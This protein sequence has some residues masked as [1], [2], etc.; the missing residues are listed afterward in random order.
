MVLVGSAAPARADTGDTLLTIGYVL[1]VGLGGITTAVNGVALA[2]DQPSTHAWRLLGIT[3]G[4][5]DL[6]LG[7]AVFATNGDTSAG[8]VLGSIGVAV[9]AAALLTGV[10][11]KEDA[12]SVG[13]LHVAGGAGVVV[14]GRF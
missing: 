11:A 4:A 7:A 14:S 8:V 6:G 2:Y 13:V 9:G 5:I 3:T 1:P 10:F 12:V